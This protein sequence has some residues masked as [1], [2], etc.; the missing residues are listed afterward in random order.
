MHVYKVPQIIVT[1]TGPHMPGQASPHAIL[2]RGLPKAPIIGIASP[3]APITGMP[4]LVPHPPQV[5]LRMC[6]IHIPGQSL[7]PAKKP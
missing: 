3:W 2:H 6:P 4:L 7:T 1:P 5:L